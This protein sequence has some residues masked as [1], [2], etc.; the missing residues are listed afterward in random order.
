[1]CSL[2]VI[3]TRL[4]YWRQGGKETCLQMPA[5]VTTPCTAHS[6]VCAKSQ[7]QTYA[8]TQRRLALNNDIQLPRMSMSLPVFVRSYFVFLWKPSVILKNPPSLSL[9]LSLSLALSL[10]LFATPNH[11]PILPLCRERPVHKGEPGLV[12]DSGCSRQTVSDDT[13]QRPSVCQQHAGGPGET[14]Q[15]LFV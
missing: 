6:R 15:I 5:R 2:G 1:M 14:S 10:S 12:A 11:H 4:L 9:S 7:T 13:W 8:L 3:S